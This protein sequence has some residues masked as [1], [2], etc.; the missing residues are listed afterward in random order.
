M[1]GKQLKKVGSHV[2]KAER[3]EDEVRCRVKEASKCMVSASF[4]LHVSVP[5]RAVCMYMTYIV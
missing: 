4:I 2:A 1:S 3:V 5:Y